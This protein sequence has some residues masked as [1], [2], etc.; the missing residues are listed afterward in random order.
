MSILK[1][2]L[3]DSGGNYEYWKVRTTLENY[4]KRVCMTQGATITDSS[5]M[6]WSTEEFPPK[7]P[8]PGVEAHDLV[9]YILKSSSESIIRRVYKLIPDPD[10]AGLTVQNGVNNPMISEVYLDSIEQSGDALAKM[11]FHELMHNKLQ[12]YSDLHY[13]CA[14]GIT[15]QAGNTHIHSGRHRMLGRIA[16][17]ETELSDCD[18]KLMSPFLDRRVQQYTGSILDRRVP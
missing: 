8:F 17:P 7:L 11:I 9:V 10:K 16:R 4:F 14:P 18:C 2:H 3:R 15:F 6:Y 5:V 1:I 13:N 12:K